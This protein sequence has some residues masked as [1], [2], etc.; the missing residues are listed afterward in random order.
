LKKRKEQKIGKNTSG[1]AIYE[2]IKKKLLL[3]VQ[4]LHLEAAVI[5]T[6]SDHLPAGPGAKK[7]KK[8]WVYQSKENVPP[9][10][11]GSLFTCSLTKFAL[12]ERC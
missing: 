7:S 2:A 6:K 8:G 12:I 1:N 3:D 4:D 11:H 5:P 9:T 10:T